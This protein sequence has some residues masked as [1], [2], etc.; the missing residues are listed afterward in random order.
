MRR[1]VIAPLLPWCPYFRYMLSITFAARFRGDVVSVY[2]DGVLASSGMFVLALRTSNE[3][4]LKIISS[5]LYLKRT[6]FSIIKG[7]T[8]LHSTSAPF[9]KCRIGSDD[10]LSPKSTFCGQVFIIYDYAE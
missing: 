3:T 8:K 2:V 6:H 10:R 1:H 7:S 5:S 4:F 9:L